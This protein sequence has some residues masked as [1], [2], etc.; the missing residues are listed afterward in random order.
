MTINITIN[1]MN[2]KVIRSLQLC[3][4]MG[5]SVA[6]AMAADAADSPFV[7]ALR[8]KPPQSLSPAD[9][10][11]VNDLAVIGQIME[12]LVKFNPRNPTAP[13]ELNLASARFEI[14]PLTYIFEIRGDVVFHPFPGHP[15]DAL[16]AEDVAFSIEYSMN[17]FRD[18]LDN[19][20][21]IEFYG[22]HLKIKLKRPMKDFMAVLATSAGYVTSKRYFD[23]LGR[24][25]QERYERFRRAPI[26]TGPYLLRAPLRVTSST[27]T[28]ER[29]SGYRDRTWASSRLSL[30]TVTFRFYDDPQ[31]ILQDIAAGKVTLTSLPATEF[32]VGVDVRGKGS[33]VRLTPPFLALL[34]INT[35]KAP[36][37]DE[38]TRQLL[39]AAVDVSEVVRIC[40][41]D[42]TDL[43]PGYRK[44]MPIPLEYL[45]S[46]TP[47]LKP[48]LSDRTTRLRLEALR[49][50][51][52]LVILAPARPDHTMD[53][54]LERIGI[55]FKRN[56]GIDVIIRKEQAVSPETIA[57]EQPDLIY[58]EWTPDIPWENA[59]L[60]ILEPL[61]ASG[62]RNNFGGYRDKSLDDSLDLLKSITDPGIT[63]KV[64]KDIQKRLQQGAPLIWL[65]IVREMTLFLDKGYRATYAAPSANSTSTL[66][67][68]TTM[69][70]DIRK[71]S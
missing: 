1:M 27:I 16:T 52:P 62:S 41:T 10:Y 49:R 23:S 60:S 22:K 51:G 61:F 2:T 43:P 57:A 25:E 26:G 9:A 39:N 31:A 32:G 5:V 50:A 66:V 17:R 69:L 71:R 59:D 12:G 18:R 47:S 53:K 28:V 20:E 15:H 70:K 68:Y 24:N 21:R 38:R 19:I 6:M 64:Y 40:Q 14:D 4:L 55:D 29:F 37:G 36:L 56:L 42:L 58:R 3:F 33:F 34:T 45:Q 7:I 63:E 46:G 11:T 65:P 8:G 67:F 13:P 30:S 54:I 35:R 48:M 44:Y